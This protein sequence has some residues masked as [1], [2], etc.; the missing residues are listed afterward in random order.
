MLVHYSEARTLHLQQG[1]CVVE[2]T[3]DPTI[4]YVQML[5]S[6]RGRTWPSLTA[7]TNSA[8]EVREVLRRSLSE[9]FGAFSSAD[10]D[11]MAFGSLARQEW[12]SGSDVDWMLLIDGQ[13]TPDHRILARDVGA[14]ILQTQ[15]RGKNLRLPGAEGIFGNMAFSHDIIHH[16]GGQAD[17]NRNTTQRVLML[18]E[19]FPIRH[20]GYS[21]DLGPYE[22]VTRNILYRYLHDDTNFASIDN[23][24]SRIP[25]FLL[26]DVVRYW[27]TMCVDFAYKEWEQAGG[28]WVIRN[29]KLRMSRKLLFVSGLLTAFSCY[30]NTSLQ[31]E[32]GKPGQYLP[33]MQEHL[34]RFVQATSTNILVWSLQNVGLEEH[35]GTILNHYDTFLQRLDD[36]AIRSHLEK[37]LPQNVYHDKEFLEL[38]EISHQFQAALTSVFF[39]E[40]TE[41]RDFTI[42]YGVF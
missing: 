36:E 5:S 25:R 10:I 28:K 34:M 23:V 18:L 24:G 3:I 7:A 6:Q 22:R 12:T 8:N 13:A 35:A 11:V 19:A 30:R 9:R 1:K 32:G 2:G 42:D 17:T 33:M 26:N 31:I 27:R 21:S 37:L 40:E 16:I 20:I 15:Y 38:R 4:D 39:D 29:I 14:R 41:L